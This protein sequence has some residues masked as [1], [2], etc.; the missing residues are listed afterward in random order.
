MAASLSLLARRLLPLAIAL[1]SAG[2]TGCSSPESATDASFTGLPKHDLAGTGTSTGGDLG[3]APPPGLGATPH[4]GGTFFRLWA[5]GADRV[6]VV[7]EWNG[8]AEKDELARSTASGIFSGDVT[9]AAVGQKYQ[10]SVHRGTDVLLRNDPRARAVTDSAG[11]SLIVDP[12]AFAW[13]SS[14]HPIAFADQVLYELHLGSFN[15][16][17][18]QPGTWAS[19][20]ERLDYLQALGVNMLEVMPPNEFPGASSW[21]Y[22]PSLPF[23]AES[24]YGTPDDMR[25][26]V[27]AAHA[28]GMGVVIDVVHNHYTR[29]DNPLVCL[30]GNCPANNG[31]YFYADAARASTP[32]GPRPNFAEPEVRGYIRDNALEWLGEYRCDGLRWDSVSNIR[33]YNFGATAIP[34]GAQMLKDIMDALHARFPGTLQVAEDLATI[35]PITRAT[36][37]GGFGFDTQ[38]DAAFFHPVDDTVIPPNDSDRSMTAIRD[39]I[40]HSYNGK[41]LQRVVYS[42]DH[43]EVANGRSRI[44]EMISPGNAGS[45]AARK[46]STL[47]AGVV[48]TAPGIP[49]IFM[50][51]EFLENGHFDGSTPLDWSKTNTYSG[52]LSL[53][54]DLI[55]LRKNLDGHTAG[56]KGDHVNVFHVN[57]TA[58]VLAWHRFDRGG[59]GDDVVVI[60]NFSAI[61]FASY[62]LGLPRAGTWR[63]RFSSDAVRYAPDFGDSA[64]PDVTTIVKA[65]DGFAQDA[66]VRLAP[67]QVM[68]LSQ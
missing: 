14:F 28:H 26:F 56:L 41:P 7:G 40:A 4:A 10:Y 19:A 38:W 60:A 29:R 5:P 55:R 62:E 47:A 46:R 20:M 52:I 31:I 43:D 3:D 33:G 11:Q 22:N 21:G 1:M 63:V 61:T 30:D 67:Y 64:I 39:A 18:G 17:S 23:A 8:F 49:M 13:Q 50:G 32:W 68:I 66:T 48:F 44:P 54:T 2:C 6:F 42:E 15:P 25:R 58:K 9:G 34:D 35:D 36:S 59:P 27:D 12:T 37:A 45:L 24:S 57:D 16:P 53:Y 65:R 51:Q